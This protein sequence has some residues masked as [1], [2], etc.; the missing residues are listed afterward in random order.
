MRSS[1]SPQEA[2]DR[3]GATMARRN[4][5]LL[6]ALSEGFGRLEAA[7]RDSGQ[8]AKDRP[9]PSPVEAR[10][11]RFEV[12]VELVHEGVYD[13]FL[14]DLAAPEAWAYLTIAESASPSFT[15]R[16]NDGRVPLVRL[17][18]GVA[19]ELAEAFG[20]VYER[21]AAIAASTDYEQ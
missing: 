17:S 5:S 15:V 19:H 7:I 13:V 2:I 3:M 12:E 11:D 8:S 10:S 20:A 4:D 21:L 1:T 16:R 9:W 14:H 6:R 18:S